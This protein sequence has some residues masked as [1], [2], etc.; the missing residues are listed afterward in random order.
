M[1]LAQALQRLIAEQKQRAQSQRGTIFLKIVYCKTC[2][3]CKGHGPYRYRVWRE[4]KK[5]RWKY[6]GKANGQPH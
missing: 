1:G 5:L 4:G 6:L 3:R 2:K